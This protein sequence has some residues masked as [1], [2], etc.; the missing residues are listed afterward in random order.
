MV[1]SDLLGGVHDRILVGVRE[2]RVLKQRVTKWSAE[3]D[4]EAEVGGRVEGE[5]SAPADEQ[6]GG[7]LSASGEVSREQPNKLPTLVK[8][9]PPKLSR[10]CRHHP[11]LGLT[12]VP[13]VDANADRCLGG[14]GAVGFGD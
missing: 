13:S 2:A 12:V 8:S 10:T 1:R 9:N 14:R 11:K 6:V 3:L 4:D 7:V 5:M